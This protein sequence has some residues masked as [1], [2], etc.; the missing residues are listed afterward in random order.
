MGLPSLGRKRKKECNIFLGHTGDPTSLQPFR[1]V[2]EILAPA[3][4]SQAAVYKCG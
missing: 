2:S 4:L 1:A 3:V